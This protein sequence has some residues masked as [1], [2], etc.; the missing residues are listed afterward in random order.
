M[1]TS[2]SARTPS[3]IAGDGLIATPGGVDSH[4]HLGN[5][6]KL[7]DVALSAGLTTL[8]GAGLNTTGHSTIQGWLR[9]F[10]NIP[11]NLALQA[12]GNAEPSLSNGGEH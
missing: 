9:S 3:S 12:R 1:L 5:N 2:L 6:P 8:V 7:M 11:V 10:E 4:V